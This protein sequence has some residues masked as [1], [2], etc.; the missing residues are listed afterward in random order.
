MKGKNE[1]QGE[2]GQMDRD[3]ERREVGKS[4]VGGGDAG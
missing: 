4:A 3:R 1:K 2:Q